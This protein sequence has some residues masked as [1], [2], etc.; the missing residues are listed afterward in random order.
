MTRLIGVEI[1]IIKHRLFKCD[2]SMGCCSGTF[3]LC[4]QHDESAGFCLCVSCNAR[5]C[6]WCRRECFDCHAGYC[7]KC[8]ASGEREECD[9]CGEILDVNE[10]IP[11]D[12]VVLYTYYPTEVPMGN[13][14]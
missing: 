11:R 9:G 1:P 7:D 6:Y 14:L 2:E 13:L 5:V 8:Y 4:D 10:D 3:S 12:E